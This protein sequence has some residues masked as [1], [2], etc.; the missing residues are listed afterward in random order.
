MTR[1]GVR[2]YYSFEISTYQLS[3]HS[4]IDTE[5]IA[6]DLTLEKCLIGP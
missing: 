4:S 1:D 2:V 5:H 3:D 6:V